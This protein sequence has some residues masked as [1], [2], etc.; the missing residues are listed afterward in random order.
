MIISS[1]AGSHARTADEK[2]FLE[3][4]VPGIPVRGIT[5]A[6]GHMRDA[7]FPLAVAVAALSLGRGEALPPLGSPFEAA[8]DMPSSIG[9]LTVG[10]NAGEGMAVVTRK[11]GAGA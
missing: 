9:V 6:F 3:A 7:Q 1:A 4:G 5:S 11:E 10:F 8:S 2:A